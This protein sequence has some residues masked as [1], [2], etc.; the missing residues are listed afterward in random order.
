MPL[1]HDDAIDKLEDDHDKVEAL[2]E[3]LKDA[4]EA[5]TRRLGLEV[6]NLVKIHM[7]L[8][9]EFLYPALRQAPQGDDAKLTEGLVEHDTGKLLI[10]DVLSPDTDAKS[11][12]AKLQVLGEQMVHHHKEEEERG[13][14]FAQA[15]ASDLDLTAMLERMNAREAEL[16]RALAHDDLPVSEMNFAEPEKSAI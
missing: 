9:E 11:F 5:E 13:G 8:E 3:A 16:Q 10:N 14:V 6:A 2:F 7:A 15:R 1:F 4:D 12:A